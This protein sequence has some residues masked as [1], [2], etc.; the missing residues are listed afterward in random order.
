[1]IYTQQE[2]QFL[3]ICCRGTIS[4]LYWI[5]INY[6]PSYDIL[7][8]GV[9]QA[10]LGQKPNT[11]NVLVENFDI[12]PHYNDNYL[13]LLCLSM[14]INL[15]ENNSKKSKSLG[16]KLLKSKKLDKQK[17]KKYIFEFVNSRGEISNHFFFKLYKH[18]F[19]KYLPKTLTDI[20]SYP[21][22]ER[23]HSTFIEYFKKENLIQSIVDF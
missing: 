14:L 16:N 8:R 23:L 9:E 4:D 18:P 7:H 3:N 19:S 5:L 10:I 22:K 12:D 17:L 21:N 15:N 11:L 20:D 6:T 1:M 13:F 2:R